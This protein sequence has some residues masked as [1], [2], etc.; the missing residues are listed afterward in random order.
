VKEYDYFE[1]NDKNIAPEK[2]GNFKPDLVNT[3]SNT[4]KVI[5][6]VVCGATYLNGAYMGKMRKY[7]KSGQNGEHNDSGMQQGGN[8]FYLNADVY[9][10]A[11]SERGTFHSDT[12]KWL[13]DSKK[14]V[15][16]KT[17][18]EHGLISNIMSIIYR[19]YSYAKRN[20]KQG[21]EIK[22]FSSEV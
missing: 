1:Y 13:K 21:A 20:V 8:R 3:K 4:L 12:M 18:F 15:G 9:P 5:D 22:S 2:I 14:A 16:T 11:I 7:G 17:I 19:T 6:A 10:L